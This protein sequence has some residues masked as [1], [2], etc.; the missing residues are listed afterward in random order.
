MDII[1]SNWGLNSPYQASPQKPLVMYFGETSQPG[2][3]DLIETEYDPATGGLIPRRSLAVLSASMPFLLDQFTSQRKYSEAT[4][5]QIM[6]ERLPLVRRVEATTLA[7]T[8]F[9]NRGPKFEPVELPHAA[10]LAPAFSV[11]VADLDGDGNEDVFLSQNF[12]ATQPETPRLDGG[13]GLVLRGLG[14]GRLQA[15]TSVQSGIKV[16]GEQRG[17]ALGDFD[18]DGRVDLVVTQNGASTKLYHNRSGS[19]GLRVKLKGPAWNL[20]GAGA[21]MRLEFND[22]RGPAREVHAGS[23]YW[24]QDGLTQVLATPTRPTGLWVRWPGGLVTTNPL[25]SSCSEV[26]L[27]WQGKL[28]VRP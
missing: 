17:A 14:G 11:N 8:V 20:R 18:G 1:A 4:L 13:R 12:F 5:E 10:Q 22:H 3:V 25:P 16:D 21:V 23:G 27:D 9:F 28:A 19:A 7:T 24:S 15:L 26:E 6:G 2:V